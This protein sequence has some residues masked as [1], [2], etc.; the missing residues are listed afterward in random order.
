LPQTT[1]GRDVV[2]AMVDAYRLASNALP[3]NFFSVPVPQG[4]ATK[5]ALS[6]DIRTIEGYRL[7]RLR[8]TYDPNFG[9]LFSPV[10]NPRYIQFG[11][12]VFF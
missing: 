10:G 2:R 1:A 4:F 7:Y 8:Q 9:T 6:Y 5:N 3:L 11:V 12:R